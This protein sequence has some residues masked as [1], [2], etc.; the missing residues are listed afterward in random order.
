M[1]E[2]FTRPDEQL[3]PERVKNSER[4]KAIKILH[5][6]SSQKKLMKKIILIG[7]IQ[8]LFAGFLSA[9]GKLVIQ[10]GSKGYF[11]D[12]KVTAK[13]N[14]YSIGRLY[15]TH[16]R[17]IAGFNGLDMA[18]GLSLGQIIQIPL[19][20]TNFIQTGNK[21]IPVYYT[22]DQ[23]ESLEAVSKKNRGVQI[24]DLRNWNNLSGN[25][26][27]KDTKLIIGFLVTNEMQDKVVTIPERKNETI[28]PPAEEKKQVITEE[29]KVEPEQKK[30]EPP[31]V[32]EEAKKTEVEAVEKKEKAIVT[33]AGYFKPHFE[34]QVKQ[35][36]V[37]REQTVTSGI[38][39]TTSGW[40]DAK[41]YLLIDKVEPGTIV[42]IINPTNNKYV[43]AKV[44]YGMEGI[45]QNQGYDIRISNAAASAL[46]ISEQDK[47][48]VKVNY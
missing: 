37:T 2:R 19:T 5:L 9:Q 39:K 34:Q 45:R 21:G 46:D 10:S 4:L 11:I 40:Q 6:C 8:I 16:P 26:I 42:K 32:K 43:F 3:L 30:E 36:P 22:V 47:F 28:I 23:N 27:P 1:D 48:I 31:V 20:D 41:Y 44:L 7:I 33:V 25:N 15:H 14:F 35:S 17:N 18:K 24:S 13:E 12:H 38:F 29:K